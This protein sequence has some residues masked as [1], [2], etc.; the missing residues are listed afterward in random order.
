MSA[1]KP[2]SSSNLALRFYKCHGWTREDLEPYLLKGVIQDT[3]EVNLDKPEHAY[4]RLRVHSQLDM[5]R[6]Y[7]EKVSSVYRAYDD[8]PN[9]TD[10]EFLKKYNW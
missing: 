4:Y 2:V 6:F 10:L 7:Q 1:K 8:D 5:D 9:M 3:E